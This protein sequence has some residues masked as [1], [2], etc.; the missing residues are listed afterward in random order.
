MSFEEW[1]NENAEFLSQQFESI[2]ESVMD[3]VKDAYES[4]G[5]DSQ[6]RIDELEA[7]LESFI[8]GE[9]SECIREE[10][11]KAAGIPYSR[12]AAEKARSSQ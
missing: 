11:C 8:R 2:Q 5:A 9:A 3:A 6:A 12:A 7:Q 4:G 10:A 1:E